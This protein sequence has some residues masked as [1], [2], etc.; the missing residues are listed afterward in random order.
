MPTVLSRLVSPELPALL[1]QLL[2]RCQDTVVAGDQKRGGDPS[3][4][5]RRCGHARG[6]QRILLSEPLS[7]AL[8]G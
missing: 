1:G 3:S 7:L 4:A 6:H 8:D 5:G 2:K